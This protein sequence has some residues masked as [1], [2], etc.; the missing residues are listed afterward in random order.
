[1]KNVALDLSSDGVIYDTIITNYLNK[2]SMKMCF[3]YDRELRMIFY[4]YQYQG[5]GGRSG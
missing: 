1:M 3:L 4:T 2:S 5:E